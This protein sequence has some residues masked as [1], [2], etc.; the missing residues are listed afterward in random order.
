MD[1]L[2]YFGLTDGLDVTWAHATN[3]RAKLGAALESVMMLEADVTLRGF[4]TANKVRGLPFYVQGRVRECDR[5][6]PCLFDTRFYEY[7]HI[8]RMFMFMAEP[9]DTAD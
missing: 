7:Q 3:S 5:S 6:C 1:T 8:L 2:R 9:L 4:G